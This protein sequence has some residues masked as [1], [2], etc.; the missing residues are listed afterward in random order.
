MFK[1]VSWDMDKNSQWNVLKREFN[2]MDVIWDTLY[3]LSKDEETQQI[4]VPLSV[5]MDYKGFRCIAIG[6][7]PFNEYSLR[8]GINN[9]NCYIKNQKYIKVIN[10]IGEI[11]G[12]KDVKCIFKGFTFHENI[13]VS[14][15]IKVY[16]HHGDHVSENE[17]IDTPTNKSKDH[18]FFELKYDI[19]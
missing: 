5:L 7:V 8:L 13:P 3:V 17:S 18:H 4:R 6:L 12:L 11:L 10:D 14:T 9:E 15:H 2:S 1:I 19:K 16:A